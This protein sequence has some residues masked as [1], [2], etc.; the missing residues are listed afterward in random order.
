MNKM[1]FHLS[2][3]SSTAQQRGRSSEGVSHPV[4]GELHA[5]GDGGSDRA[6]PG[7]ALSHRPAVHQAPL[8]A[9]GPARPRDPL[10][11]GDVTPE[12]LPGQR[13]Q[14]PTGLVSGRH[15]RHEGRVE[16]PTWRRTRQQQ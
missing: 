10:P 9:D 11:P 5:V 1:L 13:A 12:L 15:R 4:Q 3:V 7:P 2:S 6:G 14:P 8:A 16:Q